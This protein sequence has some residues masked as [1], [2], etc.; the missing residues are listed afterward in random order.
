MF[1]KIHLDLLEKVVQYN[2]DEGIQIALG[3][4]NDALSALALVVK[5]HKPSR[6]QNQTLC[7]GCGTTFVWP[8]PTIQGIRRE[9]K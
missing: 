6:L 9:L 1:Q 3:E 8:C 7:L 5:I 4:V 2:K